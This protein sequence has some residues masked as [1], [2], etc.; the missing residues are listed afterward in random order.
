M[1]F[2][3][4]SIMTLLFACSWALP[5]HASSIITVEHNFSLTVGNLAPT[6]VSNYSHLYYLPGS[7]NPFPGK[8]DGDTGAGSAYAQYVLDADNFCIASSSLSFANVSLKTQFPVSQGGFNWLTFYFDVPGDNYLLN[9]TDIYSY[10]Y[11]LNGIV[12]YYSYT[13]LMVDGKYYYPWDYLNINEQGNFDSGIISALVNFSEM[14]AAGPHIIQ[15][16]SGTSQSE[17]VVP[18]TSTITFLSS[19]LIILILGRRKLFPKI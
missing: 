7:N 11:T 8:G 14:L 5:L 19:G 10:N 16:Y 6:S 12:E 9:L 3:K 18:L 13:F 1:K 15:F 4:Y 17:S 2:L